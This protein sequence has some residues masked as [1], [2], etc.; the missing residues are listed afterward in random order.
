MGVGVLAVTSDLMTHVENKTLSAAKLFDLIKSSKIPEYEAN[1]RTLSHF[2]A[3]ATVRE[4][5]LL[6]IHVKV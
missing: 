1:T 2:C 5:I 3:R 6:T 4:T